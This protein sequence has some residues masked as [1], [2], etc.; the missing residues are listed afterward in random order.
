MTIVKSQ[1][2][3]G[4]IAQMPVLS[5]G[6][7]GFAT[8]ENRLFI[9]TDSVQGT[10]DTSASN[11][12]VAVLQFSELYNGN[13]KTIDLEA[14]NEHVYEFSVNGNTVNMGTVAINDTVVTLEHGL[15]R[16]PETY[17]DF[18]LRRNKEVTVINEEA[19]PETIMSVEFEKQQSVGTLGTPEEVGI[20]FSAAVK[21]FIKIDYS[22]NTTA[23]Q[24]QGTLDITIHWND[25]TPTYTISDNFSSSQDTDLAFSIEHVADNTFKLMYDTTESLRHDFKYKQLSYARS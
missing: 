10:L 17:D 20:D 24:R 14:D 23:M 16:D 12:T 15:S 7:L 5:P 21:N 6:E 1:I 9:G 8:D 18:R 22:V 13:V 2:R 25:P 4:P 19:N 11:S 3:R